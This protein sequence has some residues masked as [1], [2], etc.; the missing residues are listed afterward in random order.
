MIAADTNLLARAILG[1]DPVQ[2]PMAC[3]VL[4]DAGSI[5]ISGIVL[6]ELVW[7]LQGRKWS[8]DRIAE[9]ILLLVTTENVRV[10]GLM[11]QAGLAFLRRG[12][13]FADG[14]IRHEALVNGC[15]ETLTFDQDFARLG[16]PGVTLVS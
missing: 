9:A 13:D 3:R 1:D 16:A 10:D 11:A 5:F 6:C 7:V 2:T 15:G 4:G 14:V 12:G 8:S